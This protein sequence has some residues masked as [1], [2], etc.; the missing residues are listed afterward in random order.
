MSN[1]SDQVSALA[2]TQALLGITDEK[3]LLQQERTPESRELA[4]PDPTTIEDPGESIQSFDIISITLLLL[5]DTV[6]PLHSTGL[7]EEK[8]AAKV[9]PLY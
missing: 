6:S 5:F 2:S 3:L 1:Y 9:V 7:T 4:S 8:K